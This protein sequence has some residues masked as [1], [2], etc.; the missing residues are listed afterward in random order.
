MC[1]RTIPSPPFL[2][3]HQPP[4]IQPSTGQAAPSVLFFDEL[5]AI[6][7]TSTGDGDARGGGVGAEAR[8]LSTFLNELDGVDAPAGGDGVL[9]VGATNLPDALDPALL[10]PGRLSHVIE[11]TPPGS[12]EERL[13]VLR[14]HAAKVRVTALGGGCCC[15]VRAFW[16]GPWREG[17]LAPHHLTSW[18][19]VTHTH[20][21][22][23]TRAVGT[24]MPTPWTY[25]RW[26][27][28]WA[29]TRARTSRGSAGALR[30]RRPR[31]GGCGE[32]YVN[33]ESWLTHA[34]PTIQ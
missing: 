9:V 27:G 16:T 29:A 31:F 17:G 7:G 8:V 14:I 11:V 1:G 6:V 23:C 24:T 2:P 21:C 12:V 22:P 10:R 13:A 34:I 25:R 5:D 30:A 19:Y 3:P 18:I 33:H 20:R 32:M 26:R 28:G 4:T 15:T